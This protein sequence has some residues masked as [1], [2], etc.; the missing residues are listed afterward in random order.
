L[1]RWTTNKSNLKYI[2]KLGDTLSIEDVPILTLRDRKVA[3]AFGF[4]LFTKT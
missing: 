1:T 3:E 4:I 2:G